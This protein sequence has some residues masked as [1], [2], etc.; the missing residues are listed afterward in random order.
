MH[1]HPTRSPIG[2]VT[3]FPLHHHHTPP[4]WGTKKSAASKPSPPY[5]L[6]LIPPAD[7]KE[8][9]RRER[10]RAPVTLNDNSDVKH[11]PSVN[12]TAPGSASKLS[13]VMLTGEQELKK[14]RRVHANQQSQCYPYFHPPILSDTKDKNGRLMLAYAGKT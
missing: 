6:D 3:T 13:K 2:S 11:L 1:L 8:P 5:P 9:T 7:R 10:N 4:Q 14:A 12:T